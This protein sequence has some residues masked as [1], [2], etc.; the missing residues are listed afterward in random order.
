M[1]KP[2]SDVFGATVA[3]ASFINL[4]SVASSHPDI[5]FVAVSHSNRSSTDKWLDEIGGAGNVKVIVDDSRQIY[6]IWGL[7]ISNWAHVLS[8][9]GLAAV[10]RLGKDK[11]IWNRPTESG[12]RWQTAGSW[13]IN[14]DGIVKW[15]GAAQRADEVPDFENA[16]SALSGRAAAKL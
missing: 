4:R 9:G 15:G 16:V 3:E 8:P 2:N 7:G 10:Y 12:S 11:G 6:G 1:H 5:H 14:G 13:G